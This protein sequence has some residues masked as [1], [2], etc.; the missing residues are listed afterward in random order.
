MKNKAKQKITAVIIAVIALAMIATTLVLQPF[1]NQTGEKNT[2]PTP[3][4][5]ATQ[6]VDNNQEPVGDVK[7]ANPIR[8]DM[9]KVWEEMELEG[10]KGVG[11]YSDEETE[12]IIKTAVRYSSI[13]LSNTYFNSGEWY[14]A[15]RPMDEVYSYVEEYFTPQRNA[16]IQTIGSDG[17]L[18]RDLMPVMFFLA[19]DPSQGI[20]GHPDCI[21]GVL[22]K[23]P[24]GPLEF[25]EVD[26][27]QVKDGD[28][29]GM[30]VKFDATMK[31]PLKVNGKD[32]ISEIVYN[33]DLTFVENDMYENNEAFM[34]KYVI[35]SYQ[36][37]IDF[38][39][40]EVQ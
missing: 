5:T 13:T 4:P 12:E 31:L 9:D 32:A 27:S 22:D 40:A 35:D 18:G 24:V 28:R 15:G 39:Q 37:T 20:E 26:Y 7:G 23:C 30:N 3:E 33:Y 34:Q 8:N 19:P 17:M 16:E 1:G 10:L 2:A 36:T 29:E 21:E 14:E 38:G 6:D 11:D 25:S